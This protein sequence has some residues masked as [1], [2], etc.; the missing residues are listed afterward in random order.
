MVWVG[1]SGVSD[2]LKT[3]ENAPD[4]VIV[5]GDIAESA[6]KV[7]Y[8]NATKFFN[9]MLKEFGNSGKSPHL[10]IVPGNHDVNFGETEASESINESELLFKFKFSNYNDFL[11]SFFGSDK[12]TSTYK[13]PYFVEKICNDQL[14]LL[15]LNSAISVTHEERRG[16]VSLEQIRA[17]IEE[18]KQLNPGNAFRIA[19]VHHNFTRNSDSDN[20]NLPELRRNLVNGKQIFILATGS[21][22]LD[23]KRLPDVPNQF[24]LITIELDSTVKITVQRRI[25]SA[26]RV[27]HQ[28]RGGWVSDPSGDVFHFFIYDEDI[29]NVVESIQ[30]GMRCTIKSKT[31]TIHFSKGFETHELYSPLLYVVQ[32]RLWL[33]GRKNR[34]LFDKNYRTA[35]TRILS[36]RQN[37]FDFRVLFS[38][39]RCTKKCFT[40]S[41]RRR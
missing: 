27:G 8:E 18:A 28:G 34:K 19:I 15:G 11:K 20:E 26:Q 33:F 10:Y 1:V 30:K 21:A 5:T 39:T 13:H 38:F 7:E 40:S 4:I 2:V 32:N 29:R 25:F 12:F 6:S 22:G 41:T 9:S 16:F 3:W 31:P 37:G 24:Q 14:L 36:R 23:S 35:L 17:A